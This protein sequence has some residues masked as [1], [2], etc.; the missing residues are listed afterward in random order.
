MPIVKLIELQPGDI[1]TKDVVDYAG[2]LLISKGTVLNSDHIFNLSRR[3][4]S[5]VEIED[6]IIT[7]VGDDFHTLS[8]IPDEIKEVKNDLKVSKE[9][10]RTRLPRLQGDQ[11]K[12]FSDLSVSIIN[13]TLKGSLKASHPE[14]VLDKAGVSGLIDEKLAI[15]AALFYDTLCLE[16]PESGWE[17]DYQKVRDMV[18]ELIAN[19]LPRKTSM[20]KLRFN[21]SNPRR[22]NAFHALNCCLLGILM[23]EKMGF[24][25]NDAAVVARGLFLHDIGKATIPSEKVRSSVSLTEKEMMMAKKHPLAGYLILKANSQIEDEVLQI[26]REHHERYDGSGYPKGITGENISICGRLAAIIDV[27]DAMTYDRPYRRKEPQRVALQEILN[28]INVDFDPEISR[29]FVST[30]GYYPIGSVV[31]LSNRTLAVVIEQVINSLMRPVIR[32]LYDQEND[33]AVDEVINL[34]KNLTLSI[35]NTLA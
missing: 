1:L 9:S 27:F 6:R 31:E 11:S 8:G 25:K 20:P 15:K 33:S 14:I 24:S 13:P 23:A 26:V 3:N 7:T 10:L 4:V 29:F 5:Q 34:S 18:D 30:I 17:L 21:T 32:I 19:L 16:L 12:V 22:Y 35:S 28:H 2:R